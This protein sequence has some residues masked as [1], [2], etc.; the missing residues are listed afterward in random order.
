MIYSSIS[1]RVTQK[2]DQRWKLWFAYSNAFFYEIEMPI[3][4][5]NKPEMTVKS[6]RGYYSFRSVGYM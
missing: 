2:W 5:E 6:T 1:I 3:L 4:Y